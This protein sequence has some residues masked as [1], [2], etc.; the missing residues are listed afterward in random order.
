M[1]G[2][3]YYLYCIQIITKIYHSIS[4]C[5]EIAMFLNFAEFYPTFQ[6]F[7]YM[8]TSQRFCTSNAGCRQNRFSSR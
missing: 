4:K 1:I 5:Q 3:R 6:P 2:C 8:A 7:I